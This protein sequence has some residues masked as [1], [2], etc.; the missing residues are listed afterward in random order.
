MAEITYQMV[1][2]TIQTAGLLIGIFYYIMTLRNQERSRQVTVFNMLYS[3]VSDPEMLRRMNEL[4]AMEWDDYHDFEMKYGSDV[5]P[6]NRNKRYAMWNYWNGLGL[7]LRK[8][9]V[10]PEI[11]YH[12]N[13]AGGVLWMWKK[14]EPIIK[15]IRD[16]YNMP[17]LGVHWEYLV[18]EQKTMMIKRGHSPE[19]PEDYGRYI[20]DQ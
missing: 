12:L 9:L 11:I 19:V 16:R 10:D 14:W 4:Q 20:P 5:N 8:G 17:E 18:N 3:S 1:L 15:E 13:S 2:S 7:L 6:D